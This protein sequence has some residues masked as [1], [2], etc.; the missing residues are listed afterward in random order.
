VLQRSFTQY[1]PDVVEQV[2]LLVEKLVTGTEIR[3]L[4]PGIS[5]HRPAEDYAA[6]LLQQTLLLPAETRAVKC[7]SFS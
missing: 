1:R 6:F 4:S 7:M 2:L 5:L 3:V